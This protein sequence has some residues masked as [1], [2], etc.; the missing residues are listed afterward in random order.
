[1]LTE[2]EQAYYVNDGIGHDCPVCCTAKA[3]DYEHKRSARDVLCSHI[4]HQY[5]FLFPE[6]PEPLSLYATSFDHIHTA[7]IAFHADMIVPEHNASNTL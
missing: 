5:Y 6:Q 3:A 1:M 7:A 4:A 2:K